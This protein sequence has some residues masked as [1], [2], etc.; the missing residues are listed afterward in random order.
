MLLAWGE[1]ESFVPGF[2]TGD[3]PGTCLGL[4]S[5]C[6]AF[7]ELQGPPSAN[8]VLLALV[9]MEGAAGGDSSIISRALGGLRGSFLLQAASLCCSHPPI[10]HVPVG[11]AA[12]EGAM[13]LCQCGL[14]TLCILKPHTITTR[15]GRK[16]LGLRGS[17]QSFLL[18][19]SSA[20]CSQD[21]AF[22]LLQTPSD[23]AFLPIQ[24]STAGARAKG[25]GQQ[26]LA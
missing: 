8:A 17:C 14:S 20:A 22:S 25:L 15:R 13:G 7:K 9:P 24:D 26:E 21:F 6:V 2:N 19:C 1:P 4:A 16:Y 18:N 23:F 12:G 5:C 3:L 10:P 11:M